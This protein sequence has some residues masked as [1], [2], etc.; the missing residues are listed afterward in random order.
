[1][2]YVK[3]PPKNFYFDVT[4]GTPISKEHIILTLAEFEAMRL[5][6]YVPLKTTDKFKQTQ[7]ADALGVS[8][9]TFSRILDNAHKKITKA[10]IEGKQIRVYGGNI[11]YKDIFIGY[12]CLNCDEEWEVPTA[13]EN[14]KI[15]C[16][17]CN[18]DKTYYL[19]KEP[20]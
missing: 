17:K 6:H 20:L 4:P 12:G 3:N 14:K 5:R 8:Q 19:I 16:P 18:S 9:P 1:M 13:S 7:A 10:L 15:D 2:R 11:D